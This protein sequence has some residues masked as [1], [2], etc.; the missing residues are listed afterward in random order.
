M[1]QPSCDAQTG[2]CAAPGVDVARETSQAAT[3]PR[4]V[5]VSDPL[6]SWCWAVSP[7]IAPLKDWCAQHGLPFTLLMGG[8]RPGGGDPWNADFKAFLRHHW[9]E[10]ESRC[11]RPF[12]Y[13]LFDRPIFRYDSLPPCRAVVVAKQQLG[14]ASD[15]GARLLAFYE[16]LQRHFFV[17]GADT[18][19]ADFYRHP[20]AA[21]DLDFAAFLPE[22][23][24]A[25][26][27]KAAQAEFA[28]ARAL[29]VDAFPSFVLTQGDKHTVIARGYTELSPLTS[30][31]EALLGT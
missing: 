12:G 9:H 28:Q 3:E 10:I 23:E 18:N 4:L 22:F 26:S 2:I 5:Y 25:A 1:P 24:A 27:T 11:G 30:K 8:L 13:A 14:A 16:A 15:G 21:A 6:C 31:I 19:E 7:M 20:C 29:G 17:E